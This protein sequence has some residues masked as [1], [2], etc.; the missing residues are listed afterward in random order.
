MAELVDAGSELVRI[1]VNNRASA[2]KVPEIRRRL[3]ELPPLL[4]RPDVGDSVA[5]ETIARTCGSTPTGARW[6]NYGRPEDPD[7]ARLNGP[8]ANAL[9]E[10]MYSRSSPTRCG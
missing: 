6:S 1:T 10:G 3:A 7:E 9:P 2:A 8:R 4:N 5:R